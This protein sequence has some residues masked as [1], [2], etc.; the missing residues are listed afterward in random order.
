MAVENRNTHPLPAQ[1]QQSE[2]TA[3]FTATS[4]THDLALMTVQQG[5]S[6]KGRGYAN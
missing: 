2:L 6:L 1:E 4:E 3:E 5:R